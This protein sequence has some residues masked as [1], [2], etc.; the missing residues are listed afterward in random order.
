[1]VNFQ[2]TEIKPALLKS[3]LFDQTADFKIVIL[4]MRQ[5]DYETAS[6]LDLWAQGREELSYEIIPIIIEERALI[7]VKKYHFSDFIILG[8]NNTAIAAKLQ[9]I[10]E[11]GNMVP[12]LIQKSHLMIN[13]DSFEVR[14]DGVTIGL[15]YRE[16]EL[17]RY[18]VEHAGK[19]LTREDLLR[20]IWEYD[21][22]AGTRTVDVHIQRLRAKLGP[23]AGFNIR[24]VRGVGYMYTE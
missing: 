22:F 12:A 11:S 19:A 23:R 13:L 5:P 4:D 9:A 24:T 14:V 1:M 20:K 7:L 17:L 3:V 2:L 21:Y 8:K 6:F 10:A 15:T 16:F 18:L